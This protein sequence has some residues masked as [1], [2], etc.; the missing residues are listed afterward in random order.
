MIS[1]MG[2]SGS[3]AEKLIAA[4]RMGKDQIFESNMTKYNAKLDAY[5][6]LE[7]SLDKMSSKLKTID[8]DAFESKTSSI[9]DDNASISVDSDAPAGGYD[10]YV[11]QLAQ[12]HQLT[13]SFASET[14]ILPTT[15]TLSIQVG[16]NTA[17]TIDIDM[18]VLNADGMRTVADLRD[19]INDHPNNP[20]VQASLVRTGSKVELMMTSTE[21]GKASTIDV[22]MDG[23]DW[24]MTERKA[25]QDALVTLN[26]I[27]IENSSNNLKDVIDGVSIEL[28]KAHA[29]GDSSR[30]KIEADTDASEDAIEDFVDIFN[31]L[32]D[33][34]NKLTRSMG[35]EAL[36]DLNKNKDDAKDDK[37]DKDDKD[38][39]KDD[40][41]HS[42]IGE[43]QLGVLKGDSSIRMLQQGMRNAIFDAAPNGMR[44]SD[45]GVEMGRDG[46][47]DIDK[48]KLSKA[49]KDDPDAI[50]AMFT[51]SGSYIDRFDTIIDPFVKFDGAM[52][53]K[54]ETL[55]KQIERVETS[56]ESHNRRMK[57]RYDIYVAQFAAMDAIINQL[58]SASELFNQGNK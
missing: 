4:E 16:P 44:L 21:T 14:E 17:D 37:D 33:E 27:D 20:G 43:D 18:S 58:N 55:E 3:F 34:I 42:S 25:A 26:G 8:D 15:G 57:Q 5:K 9:S 23:A 38:K 46:K 2:G 50:Q 53:L 24:G 49:L 35:S 41:F 22:K 11:K 29:P 7:Q 48:D 30:I 52:D 12:A 51:A 39:D 6:I 36:D 56:M 31:D 40:D 13:K 1:G 32:M 19:A 45:I 28:K 54:Q 10:L 47:L